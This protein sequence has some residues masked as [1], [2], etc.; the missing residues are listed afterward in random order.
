MNDVI[1]VNYIEDG[2]VFV[3]SIDNVVVMV[4]YFVITTVMGLLHV[5][6]LICAEKVFQDSFILYCR[7][8]TGYDY[9]AIFVFHYYMSSSHIWVGK[10]GSVFHKN[11][12][13]YVTHCVNMHHD[14]LINCVGLVIVF[15]VSQFVIDDRIG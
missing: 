15:Y 9:D 10:L 2:V 7:P 3:Y 12:F 4:Q 11:T 1:V 6:I 13:S 14:I 5:Y 8:L